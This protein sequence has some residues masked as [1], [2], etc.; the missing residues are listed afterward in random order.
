MARR[1]RLVARS[2]VTGRI[3]RLSYA[4][5]HPKTTVVHRVKVRGSKKG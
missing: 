2:A 1:T 3:V 4:R 5:S